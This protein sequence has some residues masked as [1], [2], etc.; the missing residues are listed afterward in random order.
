MR[1]FVRLITAVAGLVVAAAGALLAIESAWSLVRPGSRGLVLGPVVI[2]DA[3]SGFSWDDTPVRI[4]AVAL[5]VLGV[6]LSSMTRS[7]ERATAR[8]EG[9]AVALAEMAIA[10][11]TGFS[12]APDARL[13]A[14][15]C[16]I[17]YSPLTW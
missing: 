8:N 7:D 11:E 2:R 5:V 3:L 17:A 10:G 15:A 14:A 13:A 16:S 4:F 12:V 1:L 6:V 9:L